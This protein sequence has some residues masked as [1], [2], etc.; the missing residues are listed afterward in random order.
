MDEQE[1]EQRREQF[2]KNQIEVAA[3]ASR[4]PSFTRTLRLADLK[5]TEGNRKAFALVK[6]FLDGKVKV[7]LALFI[8]IPGV[9]KTTLAYIIAWAF[10]EAGEKVVYFQAEELLNELQSLIENGKEYGRLW[11]RLKAADLVVIDDLAAQNRTAWRDAQLDAL[12]DFR[13]RERL[14]LVMTTNKLDLSERILDRVKEGASAV[15]TGES[16][17]GKGAARD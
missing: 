15:I 9:G 7:P 14:P 6:N 16:W 3:R 12:V 10:L 1:L 11:A 2:W 8:G 17:R 5:A 4:L 13:Y